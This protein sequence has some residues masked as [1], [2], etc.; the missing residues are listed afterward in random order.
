MVRTKQTA[1]K[2]TG[3]KAPRKQLAT[4][5]ARHSVPALEV[6]IDRRQSEQRQADMIDFVSRSKPG[7][8]LTHPFPWPVSDLPQIEDQDERWSELPM[9]RPKQNQVFFIRC[10]CSMINQYVRHSDH[11][12]FVPLL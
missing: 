4:I 11:K 6:Q 7:D 2:S 3:G 12:C 9:A 5:A 1:R 8:D 10:Q